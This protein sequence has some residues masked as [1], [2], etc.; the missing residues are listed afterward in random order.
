MTTQTAKKRLPDAP[1]ARGRRARRTPPAERRTDI[2]ETAA[3]LI[4]DKGYDATSIQDIA[5]ACH[6]TKAGLYHHIRSKEH[7]LLEIMHY[8]MDRFEEQVLA[9]FVTIADPLERLERAMEL[10]I[11][12]VTRGWSKE[13]TIILHEHATLTGELRAQ[14]NARKKRYIRFLETSFAEAIRQGKFRP[15]H[16]KVAAFAFLGMVNW[17][18]K[19]FKD[20]GELSESVLSSEM[21][22]LFFGHAPV[23]SH[24]TTPATAPKASASRKG[25]PPRKR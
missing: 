3:K 7:L 17:I 11:L 10:N 1:S 4:C 2:L 9:N 5:D 22:K 25:R 8:G 19:W 21:V 18:Y 15:V 16:P 20:G 13:V 23:P 12:L 24:A 6:L 14:I